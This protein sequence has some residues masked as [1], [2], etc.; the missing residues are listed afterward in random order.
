MKD[1]YDY[2][3][4]QRK[5]R[6]GEL[7]LSSGLKRVSGYWYN[8]NDEKHMKILKKLKDDEMDHVRE[9]QDGLDTV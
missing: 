5:K 2:T 6:A 1:K 3:I 9:Y 7:R 8:P 4:P